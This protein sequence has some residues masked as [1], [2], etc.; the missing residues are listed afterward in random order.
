[1]RSEKMEVDMGPE[2]WSSHFSFGCSQL[3]YFK[4]EYFGQVSAG[5]LQYDCKWNF[6]QFSFQEE[7]ERG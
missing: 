5:H 1:M 6:V 3:P 7:E 4:A 2:S